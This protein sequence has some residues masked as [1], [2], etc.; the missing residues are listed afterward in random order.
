MYLRNAVND[1]LFYIGEDANR[2]ELSSTA[3]CFKETIDVM[4]CGYKIDVDKIFN[5]IMPSNGYNDVIIIKDIDMLSMCEHHL[6]PSFGTVDISYV[7][8]DKIAGIGDFIK[9]VNAL[10]RRLQI[11]ERLTFQIGEAI[12]K[13]LSPKGVSICIKAKHFC[14][15][16]QN[17]SHASEFITNYS[18]G[19]LKNI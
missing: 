18:S 7:P 13:Y 17:D 12:N 5:N 2:K 9:L 6:L 14:M 16:I 4:L 10:S 3:D 11:Q 8:S 15:K 1:I 19:I